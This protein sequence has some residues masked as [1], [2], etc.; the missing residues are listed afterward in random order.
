MRDK[1]K[2]TLNKWISIPLVLFLSSLLAMMAYTYRS[3]QFVG[4]RAY[5]MYTRSYGRHGPLRHATL[6]L[7]NHLK[8]MSEFFD[9]LTTEEDIYESEFLKK[10]VQDFE[11]TKHEKRSLRLA[12]R[13]GMGG[14]LLRI[15][16]TDQYILIHY[17]KGTPDYIDM[18][19][20]RIDLRQT[21]ISLD[22]YD[23]IQINPHS[24][25]HIGWGFS[26]D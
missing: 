14:K 4:D 12:L 21:S 25:P 11:G 1:S 9:K 5:Y 6:V 7:Y 22:T 13:A 16:K 17:E 23:K 26:L 3:D 18:R 19:G 10:I 24:F 20:E 15:K 2:Y 8:N